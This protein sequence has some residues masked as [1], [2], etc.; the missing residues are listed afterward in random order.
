MAQPRRRAAET[1]GLLR[2]NPILTGP[3]GHSSPL[4]PRC[5]RPNRRSP[6]RWLVTAACV[7]ASMRR[8]SACRMVA[9]C[10]CRPGRRCSV[11]H[12]TAP[13]ANH[14][15]AQAVHVRPPTYAHACTSVVLDWRRLDC[16]RTAI[17]RCSPVN[18]GFAWGA[19]TQ[20]RAL[21]LH[22]SVVNEHPSHLCTSH[23]YHLNIPVGEACVV[24]VLNDPRTA[25]VT[26]PAADPTPGAVICVRRPLA[27]SLAVIPLCCDPSP[28]HPHRPPRPVT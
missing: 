18:S 24:L 16:P 9:P 25:A 19:R 27:P 20:R 10:A 1:S 21:T 12:R 26:A 17:V 14:S 6:G 5:R 2:L 7:L 8:A 22:R 15:N 3:V 11:A 4:T 23:P 28:Y 13:T